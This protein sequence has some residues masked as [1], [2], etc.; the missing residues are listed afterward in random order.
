MQAMMVTTSTAAGA[1]LESHR[2]Q[3]ILIELR[4]LIELAISAE[5]KKTPI[6]A[7]KQAR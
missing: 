2:A 4:N 5:V 1:L 3:S 6:S 7:R